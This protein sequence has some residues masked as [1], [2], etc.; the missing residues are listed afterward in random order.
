MTDVRA[1]DVQDLH[2]CL[3]ELADVFDGPEWHDTPLTGALVAAAIR[4][5]SAVGT[6]RGS[7]LSQ[8]LRA[9]I[10]RNVRR[11]LVPVDVVDE[12]LPPG[13]PTSS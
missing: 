8:R 1:L 9:V 12:R 6:K 7:R 4:K 13:R 11:R 10:R 2:R 3:R 5:A